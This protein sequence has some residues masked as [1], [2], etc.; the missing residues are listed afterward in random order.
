[1]RLSIFARRAIEIELEP[2]SVRPTGW[3]QT[4]DRL[5]VG[6]IV[7]EALACPFNLWLDL[8]TPSR[9]IECGSAASV[10]KRNGRNRAARLSDKTMQVV[11]STRQLPSPSIYVRP[12]GRSSSAKRHVGVPGARKSL[13]A[14]DAGFGRY[15]DV[16]AAYTIGLCSV[17][18]AYHADTVYVV[19]MTAHC[20][21]LAAKDGAIH[22]QQTNTRCDTRFHR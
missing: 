10:L 11:Q 3:V 21:R 1:M 4:D 14:L 5:S 22:W 19:M 15:R 7:G 2:T 12:D 8:N 13:L 18:A 17:A 6:Q 9:A 20:S 16:G